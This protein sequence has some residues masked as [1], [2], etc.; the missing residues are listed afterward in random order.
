M[1]EQGIVESILALALKNAAKENARKIV[2]IHLV[3]GNYTGVVEDAVNFYFGFLSSNTIAAGA[4]LRYTHVP[5]QLRCRDCDILFPMQ[6][7]DYQCPECGERRVEIVGGRELYIE[8]MEV[9]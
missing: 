9:E 5:G 2:A 4:A 8:K 6:K 3:V 1:H 7:K